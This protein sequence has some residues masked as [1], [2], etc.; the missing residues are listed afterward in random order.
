M[1]DW[2]P[3]L[4]GIN[5]HVSGRITP[6]DAAR[7]TLTAQEILRRFI[8][9][10]GVVL[11]DEVGTGKTFVSLAVAASVA[12]S[13]SRRRPVVVMVPPG[14]KEKWPRDFAMF[15]ERC[16]D[17]SLVGRLKCG[18]AEKGVDFLKL[19]DDPVDRRRQ[20]IFLTH[21]A[22]QRAMTDEWVSLAVIRQAIYRRHGSDDLKRSLG[23]CVGQLI[24]GLGW[25]DRRNSDVWLPLLSSHPD[26]WASI[27][28]RAGIELPNDDDPV[29]RHL[30]DALEK[31]GTDEAYEALQSIPLRDS[32]TYGER[33]KVAREKVTSAISELWTECLRSMKLRLPLLILDEAHHLKNARTRLASLF[34]AGD[35]EADSQALRPKGSLGGVF[36]RMLFLTATP[37]Q[38]GHHELCSVIQRFDGIDWGASAPPTIS[39]DDYRNELQGLREKLDRAQTMALALN[40]TWGRLTADDLV[41]DGQSVGDTDAWWQRAMTATSLSGLG[42]QVVEMVKR[43][44]TD[45][46]SAGDA[47]RPWVIRHLRSKTL[48]TKEGSVLRRKPFVGAAI[49]ADDYGRRP[50]A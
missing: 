17:P 12:L 10:P 50:I 34:H 6:E 42:Q 38:L 19:L 28:R 4:S 13:D 36:E 15:V 18:S 35:A 11:A 40:E 49:L 30:I 7:Q 48:L 44:K 43:T 33:L 21:G 31:I 24:R 14:L 47:L 27:L 32:S 37:F 22:M 39:R 9:R 41:V 20:I 26:E 2:H 5:L 25:V 45:F 16:L 23:R 1:S 8:I 46:Q 29:P 3:F